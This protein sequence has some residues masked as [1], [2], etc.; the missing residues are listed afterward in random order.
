MGFESNSKED[1]EEAG[2]LGRLK[3][4]RRIWGLEFRVNSFGFRIQGSGLKVYGQEFRV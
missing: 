4:S 2:V 3:G 1:E